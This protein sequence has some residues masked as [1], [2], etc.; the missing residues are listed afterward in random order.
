MN[1]RKND[2][3]EAARRTEHITG[4]VLKF[5]V[6]ASAG[7]IIIGLIMAVIFPTSVIAFQANPTLTGLLMRILSGHIDPL[8]LMFAGLV[9]LM[10]T[11]ILRVITAVVGFVMEK[12]WTFVLVSSIV[13]IM[14]LGEIIYSLNI[15]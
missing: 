14:L 9:L 8:T 2:G 3:Q 5:G 7:L 1:D 13:F 6:W 11:P 12:N 10:F 4:R 15:K